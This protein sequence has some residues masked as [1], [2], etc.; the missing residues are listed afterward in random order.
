[1][2]ENEN[3]T[4]YRH[5]AP[6]GKIYIGITQQD[7]R[8]RWQNGK[9]YHHNK[10]FKSAIKKYGWENFIH[11]ILF[12]GLSKKEACEKEKELIEKYNSNDP[13]YGY[14]QS[15]GG[16]S[17]NFGRKHREETKRKMS[18]AQR[19]EKNHGFGKH[20]SEE[21]KEKLRKANKGK[22]MSEEAKQKISKAN[23]GRLPWITGKHWPPEMRERMRERQ[24][25]VLLSEETKRKISEAHK[26]KPLS[27]DHVAKI[28]ESHK[29]KVV[30]IETGKVFDSVKEAAQS[31]Q[32][33]RS[34]ISNHLA[35]RLKTAGG[36]HWRWYDNG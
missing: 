11:E 17:G 31:I 28:A 7:V 8:S 35:G 15:S 14:N 33:N 3:Y 22:V 13:D 29:K 18:E 6:N 36:Y 9:G 1:M 19:G 12:V 30:C 32:L 26:G 24:K 2:K 5:V 20:L 21:T 16:E 4:V 25:G 10:H 27:K 23:K 34:N